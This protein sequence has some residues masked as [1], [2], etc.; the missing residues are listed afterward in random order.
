[1]YFTAKLPVIFR[2]NLIRAYSQQSPF[3]KSCHVTRII[4]QE[5]VSNFANLT[6]DTNP[7]HFEGDKPIVHGAL[8]LGIV[9]GIIGTRYV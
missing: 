5:D 2:V 8:L 9:S 4:S 7:L 1:M 6:G 3:E